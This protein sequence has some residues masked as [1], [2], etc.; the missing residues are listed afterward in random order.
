MTKNYFANITLEALIRFIEGIAND[1]EKQLVE[2][3]LQS[4]DSHPAFL[5]KIKEAWTN[6]DNVK[7]LEP[8]TVDT[9]WEYVLSQINLSEHQMKEKTKRSEAWYLRPWTKAAAAILLIV[10]VGG[11]FFLGRTSKSNSEQARVYNQ[12]VVPAGEKSQLVLSDGSKVWVNA[13]STLKFPDHFAGDKREVWLDGEAF[14]EVAKNKAKPFFVHTSDLNIKVLGTKFNVKAYKDEDIIETTLVEGLV[15][16]EGKGTSNRGNKEMFLKP[17]HKA[18]FIKSNVSLVTEEIQREVS[19]PL[20]PRKIIISNTIPV[21]PATSWKE[22]KLVFDNETLGTIVKKLE[23]CY[24]VTI[25][26]DDSIKED[27]YTGVLRNVSIEQA[28]KA[29]QISSDFR[30]E[31]KGNH[32]NIY[33][34]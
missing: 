34:N 17:N 20:E 16:I 19:Q 26:I 24:N 23:R 8:A 21:E 1:S 3:W 29:L 7:S 30:F 15:S 5:N 18:I 27:R 2:S 12:I 22:G 28:V 32:I 14:F 13:G 33:K 11:A 4:D 6:L 31:I 9:D 25:L 10:S